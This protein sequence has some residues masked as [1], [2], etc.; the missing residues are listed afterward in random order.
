MA[1]R[2]KIVCTLGP[3]VDDEASLRALM[4]AG[5]DVARFNFS[6][7]SHDEHRARMERL[8][9]V[10]G[11]LDSPCAMLLDTRGPEIRTGRLAGGRPVELA[12][13]S[14][15]VLTERA[16]EGTPQLVSQSCPG[17][18]AAVGAGTSILVDDGLL[19]LE[20]EDVDGTDIRCIVR[21]AG[22]LGERKS[23]NV[24]GAALP[25]P[26]L[27][28]QD[29]ADLLFG[30]GQD[31]DFVAAS[32]VR[33]ADGVRAVRRFLD[34][35]GGE[36]IRI[37][38]KI[39]CSEAVENFDAILEAADG[40][41]AARGDLGVE[42]PAWRVPHIQKN[43]IRA[44]N[45]ASKPVITATQ[46][47][48]SMVR[49]PRPTRAEVG[50]VANAVYDGT[51]AVMLSGETAS[52]CYPV[53]AVRMMAQVA[54]ASEPYLHDEAAPDRSREHA[55]VALA[56]GMAAVQAAET[57]G[58]S[59]IVAPTMSGRTA[60][61]MSNL[62]P[63]VPIYA[64]TPFPRVMR[65]QQLSWGVTPML[66]DV[67]GDMQHVVENARAKVLERGLVA[68]GDIAVFTAGDRATSPL[69]DVGCG[70]TDAAA[71]N[72]LYVVQIR[73]D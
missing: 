64:V 49:N 2:T 62:R 52:G 4:G 50:D 58:A 16:V 14:R 60:R 59:C 13:G 19:E 36:G 57:L 29:R 12:A 53:E 41:M 32:F 20:V 55:R 5:M 61:L 33:D 18:A 30:I 39:E 34:G 70:R 1:R 65:Q 43:I 8:R 15:I 40:V 71:T 26:A 37:V 66:G 51:D 31:I 73:E 35:H 68:P 17:L 67:Q 7:G 38:A 54:E 11:E 42:V 25:L 48:E 56:V 6:H 45:R 44:C 47:L 23:V 69:E 22:M 10:R 27:T 72:A 9:K 46:M 63:R 24:P 3:S 21:N 28:D